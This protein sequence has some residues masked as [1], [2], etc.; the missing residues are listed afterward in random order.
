MERLVD[1]GPEHVVVCAA[2]PQHGLH[3][4]H[5]DRDALEPAHLGKAPR[6]M[7]FED[8]PWGRAILGLVKRLDGAPCERGGSGGMITSFWG[9]VW[10]VR[11]DV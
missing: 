4:E 10:T 3:G 6:A 8:G 11:M 5:G 2:W 1:V 7:P 9:G